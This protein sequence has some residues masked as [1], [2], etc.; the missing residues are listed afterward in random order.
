MYISG[1]FDSFGGIHVL[2]LKSSL[3]SFKN[4]G[5]RSTDRDCIGRIPISTDHG[6]TCHWNANGYSYQWTPVPN[7]T[8]RQ[9]SF[10]LTDG[11]GNQVD[12][13]GGNVSFHLIFHAQ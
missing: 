5:P 3:T 10:A 7:L 1:Y 8:T 13:H 11:D 12:L 9:I 6:A 4:L 2:Y